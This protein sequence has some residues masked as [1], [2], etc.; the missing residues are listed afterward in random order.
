MMTTAIGKIIEEKK[1]SVRVLS[2]ETGLSP[3]RLWSYVR[4]DRSPSVEVACVIADA[5]GVSLDML[6]RGKESNRP[7]KTILDSLDGLTDPELGYVKAVIEMK[8]AERL[9]KR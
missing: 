8:I 6:I 1:T 4:G 5:L 9:I 3:D 7:M 2:E